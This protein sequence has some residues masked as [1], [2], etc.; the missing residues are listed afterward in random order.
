M[1][2]SNLGSSKATATAATGRKKK[3]AASSGTEFAEELR[4]T[5]ETSGTAAPVESSAVGG[6]D[7][8]HTVQEVSDATDDQSRRRAR[9]Y[10]DGILETL[11]SIRRD[12]LSGGI[13]KE[14]LAELAHTVRAERGASEDPRLN[15]IIDEIELRAKVEIAKLTR[16][17]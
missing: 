4:E 2:I 14:K 16:E 17:L 13:S 9:Q 7:S 1:K 6:V 5:S 12:L 8:I 10:G 15:E 3:A 11:E